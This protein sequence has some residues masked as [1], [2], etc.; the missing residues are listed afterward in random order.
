MSQPADQGL[1]NG[2]RYI[3]I[4]KNY[5]NKKSLL[6]SFKQ[7]EVDHFLEIFSKVNISFLNKMVAYEALTANLK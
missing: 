4:Q 1:S 7:V 6:F 5:L 3:V 2:S